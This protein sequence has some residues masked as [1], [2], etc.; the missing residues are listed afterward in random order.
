MCYSII[1]DDL[2]GSDASSLK[3]KVPESDLIDWQL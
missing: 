1:T 3:E 2:E